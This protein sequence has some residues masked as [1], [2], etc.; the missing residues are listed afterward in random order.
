MRKDLALAGLE[1]VQ[2][3]VAAAARPIAEWSL[4]QMERAIQGIA[5]AFKSNGNTR[6]EIAKVV[7]PLAQSLR[8]GSKA[9]K[10]T[11]TKG[12]V[13]IE[14]IEGFDSATVSGVEVV[15][16]NTFRWL[17]QIASCFE[18]WR[19]KMEWAWVPVVSATTAGQSMILFDYDPAD[20]S[21][22]LLVSDY[23]STAD[24]CVNAIWSPGAITPKMSSWLKTGTI[25]DPRFYSPGV[26]KYNR[27]SASAGY[28]VVRYAVELRKPQP[29]TNTTL[30]FIGSYSSGSTM[31]DS[32]TQL[33]GDTN[34]VTFSGSSMVITDFPKAMAIC[35]W[36][37]D[38]APGALSATG[39]DS[40]T[41]GTQTG[42]DAIVYVV[43]GSAATTLT[44]TTPPAGSTTWGLTV[45]FTN[46]R[47]VYW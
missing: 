45:Y 27:T 19:I 44:L 17:S 9:P 18:E 20:D 46:L 3:L 4:G 15:N 47:P 1:V 11:S 37:T 28:F 43:Y 21:P 35:V 26:F 7:A 13:R 2:P 12:V 14:H 23:F 31:F 39:T 29:A 36:S 6:E 30:E 22:A 8:M 24:H 16:T 42:N 38:G 33:V 10:F 41:I 5:S 32:P 40:Y 25:G 34:L